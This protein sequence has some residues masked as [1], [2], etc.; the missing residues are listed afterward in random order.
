MVIGNEENFL[1]T[2]P[3]GK[4]SLFP[5][6]PK[7]LGG[8]IKR[9]VICGGYAYYPCASWKLLELVYFRIQYSGRNF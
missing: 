7:G 8:G 1:R 3:K 9:G 2:F 4:V 6:P 5:F